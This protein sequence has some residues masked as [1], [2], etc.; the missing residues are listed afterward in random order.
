[1]SLLYNQAVDYRRRNLLTFTGAK[2]DIISISTK[3]ISNQIRY[4]SDF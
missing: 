1:M 3:Q 2:I 4:T